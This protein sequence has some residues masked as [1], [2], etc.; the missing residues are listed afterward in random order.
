[1]RQRISAAQANL[2]EYRLYWL[3]V[4]RM[5]ACRSAFAVRQFRVPLDAL[6]VGVFGPGM[7]VREILA[8]LAELI[9]RTP[10]PR[11]APEGPPPPAITSL[12]WLHRV[13]PARGSTAYAAD[14]WRRRRVSLL[15]GAQSPAKAKVPTPKP[16]PIRKTKP[17]RPPKP[18]PWSAYFR[19]GKTAG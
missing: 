16:K 7:P 10:E 18:A 1:V 12:E 5:I 9:E 17:G 2:S 4:R 19:V 3:P 13:P 14:Y 15:R 11:P 8:D 6:L